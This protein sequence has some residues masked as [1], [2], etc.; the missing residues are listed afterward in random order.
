MKYVLMT[1][2]SFGLLPWAA[3]ATDGSSG[4]G[5]YEMVFGDPQQREL[6]RGSED[7]VEVGSENC[8]GYG[9]LIGAV[10]SFFCHMEK[11]MGI[12]GVG[13]VT[14]VFGSYKVHAEIALSSTTINSVTYDYV[15]SVWVCDTGSADCTNVAN[16]NRFYFIAFTFDKTAGI[17]KGY[18]LNVPGLLQGDSSG[19]MEIV[20]DLGSASATQTI[21]GKT[22]FTNSGTSYNMRVLGAKTSSLFQMNVVGYGGASPAGFRFAMSGAPPSTEGGV[23]YYNMYYEGSGGTGSGG[24]YTLDAAGLSAPATSGGMCVSA[25]ESGAT[26]DMTAASSANCSSFAFQAFDYYA[27]TSTPSCQALTASSILGTWQSMAAH[28]S[29]L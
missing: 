23:N 7:G 28:P 8:D 1:I 15:G 2:L 26:T 22:I 3:H 11:D 9:G 24:F 13:S 17:N 19:A 16:Y 10:N 12:T 29:A 27:A 20:Y 25:D 4:Q 5:F 18:V 14:K 6:S 21:Q